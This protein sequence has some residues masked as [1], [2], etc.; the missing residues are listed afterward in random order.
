MCMQPSISLPNTSVSTCRTMAQP[1]QHLTT[2][3]LSSVIAEEFT[4]TPSKRWEA[5]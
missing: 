1:F 2:Q 4:G 5:V 3:S